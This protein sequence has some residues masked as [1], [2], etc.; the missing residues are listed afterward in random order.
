[1]QNGHKY[2][3]RMRENIKNLKVYLFLSYT[4]SKNEITCLDFKRNVFDRMSC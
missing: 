2:D 1:M 4:R 3:I